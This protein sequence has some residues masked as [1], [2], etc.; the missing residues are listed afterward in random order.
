MVEALFADRIASGTEVDLRSRDR[1]GPRR[2][3]PP[4]RRDPALRRPGQPRRS[5]RGSRRPC[6]K[7]SAPT[8][9]DLLPGARPPR[10]LRRRAAFARRRDPAIA[11]LSD[12]AL[13]ARARR[14]AAAAARRQAPPRR[15]RS[16]RMLDGLAR[17]GRRAR[18]STGSRRAISK[19]RP[20]AAIRST[21]RPRPARPSPSGSR[22]CSALPS[23]PRPATCRSS[24]P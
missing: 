20:A 24:S 19:P 8:A 11:D 9:L 14:L 4:A 18:R 2:A 6:S 1:H 3:R 21:M 15:R 13:I 10:S 23:I 7:A 5:G 16:G 17:L 22:P 12:E